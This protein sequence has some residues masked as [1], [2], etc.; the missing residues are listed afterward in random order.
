MPFIAF[1]ASRVAG[2]LLL[3]VLHLVNQN[4]SQALPLP[5]EG[6]LKRSVRVLPG[7]AMRAVVRP[8]GFAAVVRAWGLQS[9][10]PS[11]WRNEASGST[12]SVAQLTVAVGS[13]TAVGR[14]AWQALSVSLWF[15]ASS[16]CSSTPA[17]K[18]TNVWNC[19]AA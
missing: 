2:A 5:G 10:R 17:F 6:R 11:D 15:Y 14:L 8:V 3:Q 18:C 9:G 7:T 12:D 1:Y 16:V 13:I 4:E 19:P